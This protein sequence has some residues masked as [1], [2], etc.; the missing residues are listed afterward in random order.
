MPP[1]AMGDGLSCDQLATVLTHEMAHLARHNLVTGL[2]LVI[3][4]I[5]YWWNPVVRM[6]CSRTEDLSEQICEDIAT[7]SFPQPREYATALLRFAERTTSFTPHPASLGLSMSTVSQLEIRVRRVLHSTG[8]NSLR[9]SATACVTVALMTSVLAAAASM[10]QIREPSDEKPITENKDAAVQEQRPSLDELLA[11]IEAMETA[12]MPF[13]IAVTETMRVNEELTPA[14]RTGIRYADGRVHQRL[15]EHGML[16]RKVW[17]RS[18]TSQIDG[19]KEQT[20]LSF[21]DGKRNVQVQPGEIY[22]NENTDQLMWFGNNSP[23]MGVVPMSNRGDGELF[24]AAVQNEKCKPVLTWDGDDA[25]LEF[26]FGEPQFHTDYQWTL[27]RWHDWH[28]VRLKT[29]LARNEKRE[30]I[31]DWAATDLAKDATGVWRVEK[32]FVG[33]FSWGQKSPL[34]SSIGEPMSFYWVDFAVDKAAFGEEVDRAKFEYKIPKN[35]NIRMAEKTK[36]KMPTILED[37]ELLITVV[38]AKGEPIVGATVRTSTAGY[39][40]ELLTTD[41]AGQVTS[42]KRGTESVSI[43]TEAAGYRP[44]NLGVGGAPA[45]LK[46]I[47]MPQ[48]EV[49]VVDELGKPLG[50]IFVG[51]ERF[52]RVELNFDR[53]GFPDRPNLNFG[54]DPKRERTTDNGLLQLTNDITLR[55]LENPVPIWAVSDNGD[56]FGWTWVPP[57]D[58]DQPHTLVLKPTILVE[59]AFLLKQQLLQK[60]Y[61]WSIQD[62]SGGRVIGVEPSLTPVGIHT[63]CHLKFRLPPGDYFLRREIPN[64]SPPSTV[65]GFEVEPDRTRVDLGFVEEL[66]DAITPDADWGSVYGRIQVANPDN[67]D[68]RPKVLVRGGRLPNIPGN[69]LSEDLLVDPESG[70][71]EGAFV[72][73]AKAPASIHPDLAEVPATPLT[74]DVLRG[75]FVPHTMIVRADQRVELINS[76]P[77]AANILI[78]PIKNQAY[79]LRIAARAGSGSGVLISHKKGESL[80]FAVKDDLHPWMHACWLVVDH[81]Y[82]AITDKHGRFV[83]DNLPPGKHLINVWHERIGYIKRKLDVTIE[84]GQ[85]TDQPT[86]SVDAATLKMN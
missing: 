67:I 51:S 38:N 54:K 70:G 81:P 37:H 59:A 9:V 60:S 6:L 73:L 24:Q 10:M 3:V 18:E 52:A 12:Y 71:L 63:L 7:T 34:V 1:E 39:D 35:A 66:S 82:A 55:T 2:C 29:W 53:N 19:V 64:G 44:A 83:I 46:I 78:N 77:V 16:E 86:I 50:G 48:T 11:K 25:V 72:Y 30:P 65:I 31:S 84:P 74:F 13:Q 17:F 14:Q 80:P 75:R 23:L 36:P 41:N 4:R 27:S 5:V 85:V 21:A 26:S 79:N 69:V 43:V 33:Y 20:Y 22:I 56:R 76:D 45:T 47:M 57:V 42:K 61:F 8:S 58:L 49:T 68:L 28:P 62:S 32:G 40:L 15:M